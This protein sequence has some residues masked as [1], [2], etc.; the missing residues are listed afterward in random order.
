MALKEYAIREFLG[1]DQSKQQSAI[2]AGASPDACNMETEDGGLSVAKGFVR[3]L[4]APVPGEGPIRRLIIWRSLVTT[5]YVVVAGREIYAWA[6]TDET[7]E[8]KLIYTFGEDVKALRIAFCESMIGSEDH[9]LI[10][11]GEA[12]IVKWNGVGEAAA[13]GSEAKLSNKK[14]NFLAM[15]YARLFT[16]GDPENPSRLY[17]SKQP[18][19]SRT[20]ED[21]AADSASENLGGGHVEVG[22]TSGDPITGLC[23]LSNQLLIFKRGSTYRLLGD[24]PSNFRVCRVNAEVEQMVQT[25]CLTAGDVP[26]WMTGTGLFYYDGQSAQHMYNARQ[27]QTFLKGASFSNC[28]SAAARDRLYFTAYEIGNDP[29]ALGGSRITD[30]AMVVYDLRRR[31]YMLRRGFRVSDLAAADG[32]VYMIND[33]RIIYRFEEG[34]DYDGTPID[35]YWNTPLTDLNGKPGIKSLQEL[36][37]RGRGEGEGE[38]AAILIDTQAGRS[39]RNHRYL[40]PEREEDVLEIPLKNEG[41]TLSLRFSNEAGSRW[42]ITGGVQLLYELR[43][44][45]M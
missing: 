21:W 9:L 19:D 35:A 4:T 37:L 2:E 16:A 38:G 31:T 24:R 44:R 25:A 43:L 17:W 13:F 32:T 5:R 20:I 30:N 33:G 11:S 27:L 36:Y 8:W 7:P 22:D 39:I 15:H 26:Y 6:D 45:A 28:R 12:P 29:E 41:R 23:A 1:I 10:A 34:P 14:V 3:H 42:S 40:M 18:G